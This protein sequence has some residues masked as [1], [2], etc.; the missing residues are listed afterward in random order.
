MTERDGHERDLD[1]D[2]RRLDQGRKRRDRIQTELHRLQFTPKGCPHLS[3]KCLEGV[4]FRWPINTRVT[5]P[6]RQDTLVRCFHL[7]TEPFS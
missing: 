6:F 3:K 1:R 2:T 4:V 5:G 7:E